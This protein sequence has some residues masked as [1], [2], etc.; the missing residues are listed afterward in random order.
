MLYLKICAMFCT[1]VQV[2]VSNRGLG[3]KNIML[4]M[5]QAPRDGPGVWSFLLPK[6]GLVQDLHVQLR[7]EI[8]VS[9]KN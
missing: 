7:S 9:L 4:F 2:H 1:C 6:I 5:L 3:L 8:L